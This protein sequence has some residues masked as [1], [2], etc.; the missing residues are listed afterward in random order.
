MQQAGTYFGK[1]VK[2]GVG[3]AGENETPYLYLTFE[4]THQW[5]SVT[6]LWDEIKPFRRDVQFWLTDKAMELTT[7]RLVEMG[8]HNTLDEPLFADK[9]YDEGSNLV[10]THKTNNKQKT[11]EDWQI[12]QFAGGGEREH[13]PVKA[14]V[15]RNL[16][17]KAKIMQANFTKPAQEPAAPKPSP[18]PPL[19]PPKQND[20]QHESDEIRF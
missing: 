11:H 14:D 20:I 15:L 17:N 10:C 1:L 2:A 6:G 18:A 3:K 9:W 7:K 16:E 19:N 13:K 5:N 8:W 4:V 12:E